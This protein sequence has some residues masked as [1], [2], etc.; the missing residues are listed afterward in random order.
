MF[1]F[2][3]FFFLPVKIISFFF[4]RVNLLVGEN[5]RNL[6]RNTRKHASRT[7]PASHVSRAGFEP[8]SVSSRA[9]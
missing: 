7:W 2:Y 9:I 3:L 6:E 5:G 8:T 1:G 4:R